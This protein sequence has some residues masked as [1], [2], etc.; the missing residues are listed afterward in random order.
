M[1]LQPVTKYLGLAQVFV[2]VVHSGRGLI[3][4]FQGCSASIGKIF[5][6]AWGLGARLLFYGVWALS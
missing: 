6:L 4:D 5:I 2:W 1:L 3:S